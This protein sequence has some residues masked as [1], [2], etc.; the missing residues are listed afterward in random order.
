MKRRT[1]REKALQALFQIDISDIDKE[2]AIEHVLEGEKSDSYLTKL[3]DGV[4]S[5]QVSI[6]ETIKQYLENWSLER[7]ANV[8]RNILR[9]TAYEMM[10]GQA[11]D[12]PVNVAIDEAV[13]IA[14]LYGDDQSGR[15]VNG[16][17]S[18]IKENQQ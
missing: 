1:A 5:H 7:I 8:D 17:L 3:V 11:D 15:F 12:V 18:K 6:D 14:K 9:L 16:V 2:I 10:Y 4:L 13:E